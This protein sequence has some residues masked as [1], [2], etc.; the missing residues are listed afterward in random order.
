MAPALPAGIAWVLVCT[1][2]PRLA[3]YA[4]MVL[5][6]AL[7]HLPSSSASSES[8][9]SS[10]SAA[11]LWSV[12]VA[13]QT[14]ASKT[15][16]APLASPA[17]SVGVARHL[18]EEP[19]RCEQPHCHARTRTPACMHARAYRLTHTHH[20][21]YLPLSLTPSHSLCLSCVAVSLTLT[22]FS[23]SLTHTHSPTT[24]HSLTPTQP[25]A[26]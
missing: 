20:P 10:S 15:T 18:P 5:T 6:A 2:G 22:L 14:C 3:G 13:C 1:T 17:L 21:P 9:A 4:G 11:A 25:F 12:G 19:R 26:H 8:S 24:H 7:A 16:L 23:L